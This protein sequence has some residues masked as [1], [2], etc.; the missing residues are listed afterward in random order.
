MRKIVGLRLAAALAVASANAAPALAKDVAGFAVTSGSSEAM[1]IFKAPDIPRP[2]GYK[3]SWRM[4]MQ[5]YD[6][7]EQKLQG[8]PFGGNETLAGRPKSF[9]DGYL[10]EMVKP[11]TYVFRDFS[12][13]DFWSLCFNGASLQFT[14]KP[15]EVLY[16]GEF[17]AAKHTVELER[18]SVMTG[19]TSAYNGHPV[20]FFD[21]VSPPAF[22]PA[23]EAGLAAAA[24]MVK[25]RMPKT[26]VTPKAA[27]FSP[28]R[29]GTG[30]DLFGTQRICGGYYT[31]K[32]KPAAE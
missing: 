9:V 10:V 17:D 23:D 30:K 13:Q 11:G 2:P 16:L 4:G 19:R 32:A 24:A 8:G 15:G 12:R 5:G 14:I 21:T 1:I 7:V 3:T 26:T 6:P 22:A 20:Q 27:T 18:L 25:A 28:A 31:K 29:F